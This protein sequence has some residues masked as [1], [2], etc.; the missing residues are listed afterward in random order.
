MILCKW[1]WIFLVF[2]VSHI[3]T[4]LWRKVENHPAW[5][6]LDAFECGFSASDRIIGGLNAAL[7]QFPWIVRLGYHT[8]GESELDWMC[9]GALITDKHVVTAA[10]CVQ[11]G[12][13]FTLTRLYTGTALGVV[14]VRET[15]YDWR[16][17]KRVRTIRTPSPR[18]SY[19]PMIPYFRLLRNN[20]HR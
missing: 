19:S 10:H 15:E 11:N 8:P 2:C 3:K 18:P 4:D 14:S 5:K 20:G 13:D 7:G 12:E 9:G 1:I 6:I 16:A 17:N